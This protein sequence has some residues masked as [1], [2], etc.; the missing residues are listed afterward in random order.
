MT[1][2]TPPTTAA[3]TTGV[4]MLPATP[5]APEQSVGTQSRG[6]FFNGRSLRAAADDVR[7]AQAATTGRMPYADGLD[8]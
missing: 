3:I 2:V 1:T 6:S 7:K 5:T 4:S 8:D